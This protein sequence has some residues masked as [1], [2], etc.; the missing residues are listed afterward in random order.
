MHFHFKDNPGLSLSKG[1]P[2]QD[3]SGFDREGMCCP[4]AR[5]LADRY[6]RWDSVFETARAKEIKGLPSY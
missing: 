3:I 1:I 6:I 5:L 4:L 2:K